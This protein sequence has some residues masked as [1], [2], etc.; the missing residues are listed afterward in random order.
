V[1][2][3][4]TALGCIFSS[5]RGKKGHHLYQ[6]DNYTLAAALRSAPVYIQTFNSTF[7]QPFFS[8]FAGSK[9]VKLQHFSKE[10]F[11]QCEKFI[12]P[13]T[14]ALWIP[15]T[16]LSWKFSLSGSLIYI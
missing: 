12:H 14:C 11:E 5:Q 13:R 1:L 10:I 4:L 2:L 16:P 9:H 3:L 6:E 15:N 8:S 7:A